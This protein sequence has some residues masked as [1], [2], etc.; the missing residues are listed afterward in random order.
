[1]GTV[2]H[3]EKA[4]QRIIDHTAIIQQYYPLKPAQTAFILMDYA[5]F[6]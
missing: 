3:Q 6:I 2:F 4:Q 5:N 1:V